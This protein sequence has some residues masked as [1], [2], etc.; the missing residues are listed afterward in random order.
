[1]PNKFRTEVSETTHL[2]FF[3]FED[4]L[5]VKW[6]NRIRRSKNLKVHFLP[7]EKDLIASTFKNDS[8][9]IP[10]KAKTEDNHL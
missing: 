7:K 8:I 4:F 1:M 5:D 3:E 10:I 2:R 6:E 9:P